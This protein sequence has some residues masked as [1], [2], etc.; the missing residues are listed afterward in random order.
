MAGIDDGEVGF[1]EAISCLPSHV[2]DE[3]LGHSK[4]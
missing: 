4:V 2:L 3:A 1:E